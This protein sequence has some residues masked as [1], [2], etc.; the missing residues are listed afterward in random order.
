[1]N[2]FV[3]NTGPG[4]IVYKGA[5]NNASNPEYFWNPLNIFL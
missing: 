2:I 3:L 4:E 5:R 1:M